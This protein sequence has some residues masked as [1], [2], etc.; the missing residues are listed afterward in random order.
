L[1]AEKPGMGQCSNTVHDGVDQSLQLLNPALSKILMLIMQFALPIIDAV[2]MQD[3]LDL[4]AD[5]HLGTVTDE[6]SW[7]SSCPDLIFQGIDELPFSFNGIN[8]G[9]EGFH[10]NKNLSNGGTRVNSWGIRVD[11]VHG[12]GL[13]SLVDIQSRERGFVPLFE[14]GA[15]GESSILSGDHKGLL[16]HIGRKP[17]KHGHE[18]LVVGACL[19]IS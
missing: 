18:C 9:Y 3:L 10:T 8:I 6:L 13:I 5:F 7:G 19:L 1:H 4:V 16:D 17:S 2:S 15:H 14:E 12:N 11:G